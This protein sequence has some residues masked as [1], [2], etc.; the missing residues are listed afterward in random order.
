MENAENYQ[1]YK[2]DPSLDSVPVR[3]P[4]N[5]T[6]DQVLLQPS[7][8]ATSIQSAPKPSLRE[9]RVMET[10]K[11]PAPTP[12]RNVPKA[13]PQT[14]LKHGVPVDK[15]KMAGKPPGTT[16]LFMKA[17][18]HSAIKPTSDDTEGSMVDSSL[19]ISR[20]AELLGTCVLF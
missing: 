9:E 3:Q 20:I 19:S 15:R 11:V 17:V 4:R 10:F 2:L 16:D 14:D 5:P 13:E 1:P 18:T 8:I 12:V 7:S 6:S